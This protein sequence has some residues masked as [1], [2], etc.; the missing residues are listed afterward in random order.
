[1]ISTCLPCLFFFSRH[2]FLPVGIVAR[3]C[4]TFNHLTIV[5]ALLMQLFNN[6]QSALFSFLPY[7]LFSLFGLQLRFCPRLCL[8][9]PLSV[10]PCFSIP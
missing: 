2:A 4:V 10:V 6:K 5:L 7:P 3:I 8:L 9:P 1:M